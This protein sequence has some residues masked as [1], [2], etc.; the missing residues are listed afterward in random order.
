MVRDFSLVSAHA[1]RAHAIHVAQS[2]SVAVRTDK[3]IPGNLNLVLS[4]ADGAVVCRIKKR[5][6]WNQEKRMV[7]A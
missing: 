7:V 6:F 2:D 4:V 3:K 1:L 5:A